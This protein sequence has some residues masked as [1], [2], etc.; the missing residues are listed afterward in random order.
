MEMAKALY[1]QM[2]K[3]PQEVKDATA[4]AA[5]AFQ[6]LRKAMTQVE[7]WKQEHSLAQRAHEVAAAEQIDVLNRWNPETGEITQKLE[8]APQTH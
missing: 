7:A 3:A 5:S 6:R 8:L 2:N 4:K 1:D